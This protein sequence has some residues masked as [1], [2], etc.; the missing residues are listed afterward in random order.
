ML[1]GPWDT[2]ICRGCKSFDV[3]S[4][5]GFGIR[6]GCQLSQDSCS[7]PFPVF[8]V[9]IKLIERETSRS[10]KQ[11]IREAGAVVSIW[12]YTQNGFM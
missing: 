10:E 12:R 4:E 7:L 9:D 2:G 3:A 5:T 11:V 8:L 1:L 6:V